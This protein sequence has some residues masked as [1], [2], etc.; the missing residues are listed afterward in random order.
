M[1]PA[2]FISLR[3]DILWPAH[4]SDLVP[5]DFFSGH[6]KADVYKHRPGKLNELKAAMCQENI[7]IMPKM[8]GQVVQNVTNR[9]KCLSQVKAS[10]IRTS[11]SK[12]ILT[13]QQLMCFLIYAIKFSLALQSLLS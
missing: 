1:F 3:G 12:P 10:I 7:V 5:C 8:A 2:R 13:K 9:L 4:S 6:L 11:I